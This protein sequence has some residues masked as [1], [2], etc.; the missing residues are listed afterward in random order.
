[1]NDSNMHIHLLSGRK[2]CSRSNENLSGLEFLVFL[3][4]FLMCAGLTNL[5]RHYLV[6]RHRLSDVVTETEEGS[7]LGGEGRLGLGKGSVNFV[8]LLLRE[9]FLL[10]TTHI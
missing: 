1:M 10:N 9:H 6:F 3:L 2:V 5:S 4:D 7:I 8:L